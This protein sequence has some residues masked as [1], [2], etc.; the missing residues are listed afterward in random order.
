MIRYGL[1]DN[2]EPVRWVE[3]TRVRHEPDE[4]EREQRALRALAEAWEDREV[5][6]AHANMVPTELAHAFEAVVLNRARR[7]AF[8]GFDR[9]SDVPWPESVPTRRQQE[10]MAQRR[11]R[12]SPPSRVKIRGAAIAPR[13]ASGSGP[14]L[15]LAPLRDSDPSPAFLKMFAE[16]S[17]T[18][19][20]PE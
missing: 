18:I 19:Y 6:E 20:W 4:Q 10:R 14:G 9:P 12:P 3:D 16:V 8:A 11:P 15:L 13:L 17:L 2:I 1:D 5:A 7:A